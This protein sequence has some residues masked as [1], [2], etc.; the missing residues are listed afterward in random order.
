MKPF[1]TTITAVTV[2]PD[3]ARITRKG[4]AALEAGLNQL[5]IEELPM[6]MTPESLRTAAHGT[7]RAR[8]MSAQVHKKHYIDTPSE[9]I[10]QLEEQIDTLQEE[11][12][13]LDI[14]SEL[15]KGQ[16]A[17]LDK[18]AGH[19]DKFALALASGEMQVEQELAIFDSLR[20]Q[21]QKLENEALG[22][23]KARKQVDQ[24]LQKLIKDLDQ[25]RSSRPRERYAAVVEVEMHQAGELTL[26]LSYV[27]RKAE[28]QPLYDLRLIEEE[29]NTHCELTYLAEVT[30]K[31]GEDWQEVRLTLSTARP[32][33]SQGLPELKPWFVQPPTSMPRAVMAAPMIAAPD[34]RM[35]ATPSVEMVSENA[36]LPSFLKAEAAMAE[37]D[38]SGTAVTYAIPGV[39]SIPPDGTAHKVTVARFKLPPRL[40]Y[41]SVPRLTEAVYRRARLK[42]DS[43]YTLLAGQ[44]NLFV[45]DEFIGAAPLELTAPQGEIELALGVEDRLKV[46]R[47]L[48]RRDVDK[49]LI[50]GRRHQVYGYEIRLENLLPAKADIQIQ[51]QIPVARHEDIKV[52][53]EACEP[54][55]S[56]QSELNILKWTLSLESKEKRTLRFDFSVDC[57]QG[58]DLYGLP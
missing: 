45:A 26:E 14:Q 29:K 56:E 35:K 3:R 25:L 48:K 37:V 34:K 7:A 38:K 44:V 55:P 20:L 5:V 51:D 17:T 53:L 31:T 1:S 9:A 6:L 42:N 24:H 43:P 30:Q 19:S 27:V 47:E 8:L 32:A 57:P 13:K 2:Y 36:D 18:I 41:I 39:V 54:K 22:L 16:R 11:L 40:D 52:K 33:Q 46:E 58:M 21:S 28:W 12:N 10:H 15:L 23:Q 49:R 4:T 50:S